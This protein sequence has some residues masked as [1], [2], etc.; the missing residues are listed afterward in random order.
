[1]LRY[2]KIILTA[3]VASIILVNG[4]SLGGKMLGNIGML[5]YIRG[6]SAVNSNFQ[7]SRVN[8]SPSES[9]KSSYLGTANNLFKMAFTLDP[10]S[11]ITRWKTG[12]GFLTV[13]DFISA[14]EVFSPVISQAKDNPLM[15]EDTIQAFSLGG[16]PDQ[17][18][19]LYK[20]IPPLNRTQVISDSISV[21][22][23]ETKGMSGLKEALNF[24]PEDLYINYYLWKKA[25]QD[26]EVA[27]E[28][29][30]LENMQSFTLKSIHP[31]N[32]SL[33]NYTVGVI[34]MLIEDN[35]WDL[36]KTLNVVSYLVWQDPESSGVEDMLR[37]LKESYPSNPDW[38]FLLGELFHR[39]GDLEQARITYEHV[40]SNFPEYA[41]PYLRMGS[42]SEVY[43][44]VYNNKAT[45]FLQDAL[46][47]YSLYQKLRP[48]DLLGLTR[49][50]AVEDKLK[51]VDV[52]PLKTNLEQK[53]DDSQ[54]A[55]KLLGISPHELTLGPSLLE[56]SNLEKWNG[57]APIGWQWV[58]MF[59][60]EP[61]QY[62][63][64]F[65]G[66]DDLDVLSGKDKARIIGFWID[67]EQGQVAARAGYWA[68]PVVKALAPLR[69]TPG[70]AYLFSFDYR[71]RAI[72]DSKSLVWVSNDPEVFWLH[73][74]GLPATNGE[75]HHFVAIGWNRT[76]SDRIIRPNFES[77]APG[78][79]EF[80]NVQVR[81]VQLGGGSVIMPGK[82]LF[83]IK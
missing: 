28:N 71:T 80:D 49:L 24:R 9:F 48:N 83:Y 18:I 25:R 23:L 44:Q 27:D 22:Y 61:F 82:T 16:K 33:V 54:I 35:I 69:L 52:S 58:P 50:V 30:Y 32:E 45:E 10:S 19:S 26:G 77:W 67:P 60:H 43:S 11:P 56:N 17:A 31:T 7:Y 73:G 13:G 39:R 66:M 47:W 1:M 12:R 74:Y 5:Y 79:F 40:L 64:F 78:D 68:L 8:L 46:K 21:A 57:D 59:S 15:Y 14:A 34:P 75:W 36:S 53:L 42:I 3:I 63:L 72:P 29:L 65:G 70:V 6:I 41:P 37:S 38:Q 55:A 81:M 2:H 51:L 20:S 62:A 76:D 4:N